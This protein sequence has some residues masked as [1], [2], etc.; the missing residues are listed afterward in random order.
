MRP[1]GSL[2][3]SF[4]PASFAAKRI[5]G[6][7][8]NDDGSGTL[9]VAELSQEANGQVGRIWKVRADGAIDGSFVTGVAS[10]PSQIDPT[11]I[12]AVVPVGDGS[13]RLYI[14]GAFTQYNGMPVQNLLRLTPQGTVDPTFTP[15]DGFGGVFKVVPAQDGSGDVYV[16]S[17]GRLPSLNVGSQFVIRL[18]ADGSLDSAFD[19]GTSVWPD[20]QIFSIVPVGDGSGDIFVGG[21]F[22]HFG[23]AD[24]AHAVNALARVKATG[25]LERN[26]PSPQV[27]GVV[28][29]LAQARDG[30]GDW[31]VA[32]GSYNPLLVRYK[33]DGSRASAFST[34]QG[35]L[36]SSLYVLLPAPDASGDLYVGGEFWSYN[37]KGAGHLARLNSDGTLDAG[38]VVGTGFDNSG[39]AVRVA[40]ARDG[41]GSLYVTGLFKSYNGIMTNHAVR[42]TA[43]GQRDQAFST[44]TGFGGLG[45]RLI[46][47]PAQD[48]S[49]RLYI[50][51][52]FSAYDGQAVSPLIR[53][54]PNGKRDLSFASGF[55][56]ISVVETLALAED[57]SGDLYA[58]G[59]LNLYQG[60]PVTG[61]VRIHT[62]GSLDRAF[63]WT[64]QAGNV[65]QMVPAVDGSGDIYIR[66]VP[67]SG[68]PQLIRLNSDG[69]LDGGFAVPEP[70]RSQAVAMATSRDGSGDVVVASSAPDANGNYVSQLVRLH[71]DGSVN[72]GFQQATLQGFVYDLEISESD[73]GVYAGGSFA[74]VN[75]TSSPGIVRLDRHGVIDAFCA[76]GSGFNETVWSL[77]SARDG[78]GDLFV[79][80]TFTKYQ[81]TTMQG[82]A[83]LNRDGS[84]D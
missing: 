24:A 71:A 53:L 73:Q 61:A 44:G 67:R 9:S 70:Y 82:V 49:G 77:D 31:L 72:A 64:L 15:P 66:F 55:D 17:Y 60:S 46:P 75:G 23:T 43:D 6:L 41:S 42:L 84:A 68:T 2:E 14:G 19:P 51:G 28:S 4:T 63:G 16:A 52:D 45:F 40:S 3:G 74:K 59:G 29:T 83:R 13:G 7:A 69:T 33:P 21:R 32:E 26:L 38:T 78:S 35:F 18:N 79:G 36:G 5:V 80:G 81:S 1:D 56:V 62:D 34:G 57:G 37:G 58:G 27:T 12:H 65:L 76:V 50:G 54:L 25:A 48:G 11:K 30:S 22:S 10:T 8:V 39:L 20:G 47:M